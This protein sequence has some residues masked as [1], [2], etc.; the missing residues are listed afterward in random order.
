M[1]TVSKRQESHEFFWFDSQG[2][3]RAFPF[4]C[5]QPHEFQAETKLPL[6]IF[7]HGAG[8]RGTDLEL[9]KKHG[10]PKL[11][12]QGED[13]PFVVISPQCPLDQWW[14]MQENVD[15]LAQLTQYIQSEYS[16]DADRTYLTGMS[17]GGYGSWATAAAYP[18]L[19]AAII[20]VCG[21]ADLAIA[22][23]LKPTAAWAFHG[24]DDEIVPVIRS[25]EIVN[26]V[27]KIGGDA[28]LTIYDNVQHDSWSVTYANREIYDWL[29]SHELRN[30][31]NA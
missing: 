12:D 30:Q 9:V 10:P 21:G 24:R 23:D 18:N 8:E 16:T 4:L 28:R 6:L 26:E 3:K 31:R 13:L 27:S 11:I 1:Q 22:A 14:A 5:Y 2:R 29:L 19:F 20:P 17:M 7:L 25:K 15:G